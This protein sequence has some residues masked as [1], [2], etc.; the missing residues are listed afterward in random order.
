MIHPQAPSIRQ[1]RN[2]GFAV[3]KMHRNI[4][5]DVHQNDDGR[6]EYIVYPKIERGTRFAGTVDGDE[7][8]ATRTARA[9]IDVRLGGSSRGG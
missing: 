1:R 9:E 3:R 4:E 5:F 8:E 2:G 6:W 7:V